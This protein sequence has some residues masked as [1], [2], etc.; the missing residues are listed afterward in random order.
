MKKFILV[1]VPTTEDVYHNLKDFVS[2]S[3]PVGLAAIA[4]VLERKNYEVKIV[5]ADAEGL[6]LSETIARLSDERPDYVGSTCMTSTMCVTYRIYERL[7]KL[8]PAVK[9][10]VGGPHVSA[11][12]KQ[13]LKECDAIDIVVKGEG[14][15]TLAELMDAIE[16]NIDFRTVDGIAFRDK[17]TVVENKNRPLIEDMGRIPLPAY[18]YLKYGLYRSFV[19]DKWACGRRKP[20]GVVFTSRGCYGDCNFCATRVVFGKMARYFPLDRIKQE[21]DLLIKEYDIR[22][23]YFQDDTFTANKKLVND[24]CDYII[25]KGYNRRLVINVCTRPDAVD[26]PM[27]RK[28]RR[29]GVRWIFFGVESGDQRTLREIGKNITL[30]RIREAFKMARMSGIYTIG[31]FMIGNLGETRESVMSTIEFAREL[32]MDFAGFHIVVPFPGS[33]IYDYYTARG[34]KHNSWEDF[35]SINSAK[36]ALNASLDD[37]QLKELRTY[38]MSRFFKRPSYLLREAFRLRSFSLVTDLGKMYLEI[39]KE[40]KAG[41]Y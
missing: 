23:L 3:I 8:L 35:R 37:A 2:V 9:I 12:P 15:D 4:A 30:Q 1:N 22:I 14:D 25:D 16:K 7:K 17:G 31:S 13:T 11:L 38:A 20:V 33:Q 24:I 6:S 34:A 39:K 36:M 5:D 41:R 26:L 28:M 40:I 18:H 21:I 27:L 32:K 19:W 29:A 10:I